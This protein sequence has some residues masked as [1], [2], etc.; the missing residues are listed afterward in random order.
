MTETLTIGDR[1]AFYRRRRGVSQEVLV[2]LIG[3]TEDWPS[4]VENNKIELDRGTFP[5]TTGS[6]GVDVRCRWWS[7]PHT[8]ERD[9]EP[10]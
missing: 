4:R 10:H 2:R 5:A 1:A 9:E 8:P 3:R 7:R 6:T